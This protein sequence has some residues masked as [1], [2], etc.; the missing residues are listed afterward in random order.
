MYTESQVCLDVRRG[1]DGP[2]WCQGQ[3]GAEVTA[4][5]VRDQGLGRVSSLEE[6][7]GCRAAAAESRW[8]FGKGRFWDMKV[9]V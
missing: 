1:E 5:F 8:S 3:E 9:I 7:G 6:L 4:S 2:E